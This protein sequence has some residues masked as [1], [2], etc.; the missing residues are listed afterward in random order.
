[1]V[2]LTIDGQKVQVEEGTTILEA[3]RKVG[4][5]IPTLCNHPDLKPYGACRVC[6]VEVNRKG[7]SVV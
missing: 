6:V 7:R 5:E 1:M 3:A 2:E 4:I